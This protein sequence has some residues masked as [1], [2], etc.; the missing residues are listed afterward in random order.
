MSRRRTGIALVGAAVAVVAIGGAAAYGFEVGDDT[1]VAASTLPAS[2]ATVVR[3]TLTETEDVTGTLSYGEPKAV[4]ARGGATLTWLPAEGSI[5][6]RGQ[7]VYRSDDAP[8]VLLYGG[9]PLYRMLRSG[10]EGTDVELVERNLAELGYDGFTVDESFTSATADAVREWQSDLGV[11]DT[12][13]VEPGRVVVASGPIRIADAKASV[14]DP[15]SGPM[16]GYTGTTRVVEIALDV[17]RQH[18]VRKGTTATVTLPDETEVT[19]EVSRVG[20]VATTTPASGQSQS[21]TTIDVVVSIKDQQALGT[22]DGAPVSVTLLSETR[23]DVL[24]VPVAALVALAE[25]GY[26][27]EV[28]ADGT[29]SYVAVT[30]GLFADGRVEISGDGIAEGAVVGMPS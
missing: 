25:G 30:T 7:A 24:A 4:G 21:T 17:A 2:T 18:L 14:G 26:G 6:K 27:V 23:E 11:N 29:S 3:T 13:T 28:I 16:L 19:G 1:P 10:V 8:V 15:A 20:T 22:L 12:G 5:V 9:L